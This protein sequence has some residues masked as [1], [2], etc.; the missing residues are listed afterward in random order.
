MII[1]LFGPDGVGKTTLANALGEKLDLPVMSGTNISTWEDISWYQSFVAQGIDEGRIDE[2]NH[3]YEKIYRAH[4]EAARVDDLHGGI[5]LDSDPAHKRFIFQH[6]LGRNMADVAMEHEH[7]IGHEAHRNRLQIGMRVS[8]EGTKEQHAA[9]LQRRIGKRGASIFDPITIEASM[10]AIHASDD[11]TQ[12]LEALGQN[13][14]TVFSDT[15]NQ[16]ALS[17]LL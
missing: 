14:V 4:K 2:T 7:L 6:V 13:V 12:Q 9:E 10:A 15:I 11:L 8:V 17:T 16:T 3:F 5:I 1:S